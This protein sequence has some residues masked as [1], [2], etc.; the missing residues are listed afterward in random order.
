MSQF[1]PAYFIRWCEFIPGE[2]KFGRGEERI[3]ADNDEEAKRKYRDW[4]RLHPDASPEGRRY[5]QLPFLQK[6]ET[7]DVGA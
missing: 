3:Q 4:M 5:T 6:V 7:I 2:T 1:V